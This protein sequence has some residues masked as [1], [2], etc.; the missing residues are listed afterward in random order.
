MISVKD[1]SFFKEVAKEFNY[2]F[3]NFYVFNGFVISEINKG[4][5]FSWDN[6][7][8][9]VVADLS[10]FLKS[11]GHDIYL[12]SNRI[13]SY[14]VLAVDWLKYFKLSYSLKAYFIVSGNDVGTLNSSIEKLFF[15]KKIKHFKTLNEAVNFAKKSLIVI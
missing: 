12:I 6:H 7:G 4:V 10:S 8:K 11:S 3:G 5:N 14:S 2:P 9:L 1:S 13:N 15:R